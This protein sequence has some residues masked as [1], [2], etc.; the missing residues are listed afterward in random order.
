M[1]LYRRKSTKTTRQLHNEQP[2]KIFKPQKRWSLACKSV[3]FIVSLSHKVLQHNNGHLTRVTRSPSYVA[4]DVS[5]DSESVLENNDHEIPVPFTIDQ[6]TLTTDIMRERN[7]QALSQFGGV[8]HLAL[9]LGTDTSLGVSSKTEDIEVRKKAFGSNVYEKPPKKKFLG[10]IIEAFKDT[11]IIILFFC[12]VLSLG[13]GIKQHGLKPG[14][15][16][17]RQHHHCHPSS[18]FSISPQQLQTK[19]PVW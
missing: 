4:L 8:K 15:V 2:E 17:W 16:R 9:A 13:F 5:V 3:Y 11:T 14:M 6:N 10:F 7:L 12:A 18:C 1:E 19:A